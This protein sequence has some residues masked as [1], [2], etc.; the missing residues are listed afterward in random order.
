M[1][2]QLHQHPSA[3]RQLILDHP[4]PLLHRHAA[5]VDDAQP[6]EAVVFAGNRDPPPGLAGRQ[7]ARFRPVAPLEGTE[8]PG[9]VP[10][11]DAH[12]IV[13][14]GAAEIAA[15][16][17]LAAVLIGAAVDEQGLTGGGERKTQGIRVAVRGHG[18]QAE[19][20]GIE[21]SG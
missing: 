7:Q 5:A 10:A 1:P 13:G 14:G 18:V 16:A 15:P 19:R 4:E 11:R 21:K 17:L 8:N 3:A 9:L 12:G 6:P 2:E 20:A